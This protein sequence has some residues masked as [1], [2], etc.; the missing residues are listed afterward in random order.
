MLPGRFGDIG[1]PLDQAVV[2]D[3]KHKVTTVAG[4]HPFENDMSAS[5]VTAERGSFP[6]GTNRPVFGRRSPT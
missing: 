3:A 1:Q 6:S 2:L 4:I 5:P